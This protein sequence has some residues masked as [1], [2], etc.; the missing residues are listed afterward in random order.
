MKQYPGERGWKAIRMILMEKNAFAEVS[1]L[2][3]GQELHLVLWNI[4]PW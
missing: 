3:L 4:C 1:P 2:P